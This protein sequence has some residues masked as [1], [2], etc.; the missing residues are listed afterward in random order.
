MLAVQLGG[1]HE[2]SDMALDPRRTK[3][4]LKEMF[5]KSTHKH[6][7]TYMMVSCTPHTQQQAAFVWSLATKLRNLFR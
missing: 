3:Y 4:S 2:V 5:V 7:F 6:C 1:H